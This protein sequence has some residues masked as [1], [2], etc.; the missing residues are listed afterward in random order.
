MIKASDVAIFLAPLIL[1]MGSGW[2]LLPRTGYVKCGRQP[3]IQP[4][5]W[6]FSVAWTILY[7]LAGA[8]ATIAWRRAGRKLTRGLTALAVA[9][10]ALM[11]WWVVFA[12]TCRPSMAFAAIVPAAGL[13]VS[14]AA[15]LAADG[16]KISA[17]LLI[18]LIA[19]MSFASIL[20]YLSIP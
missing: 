14:A 9:L 15:L 17:A 6:V 7:I 11:A 12:N 4:P 20:S 1:G 18:P 3:S 5:G 13:V 2:L 16:A 8:A 19:W 10:F